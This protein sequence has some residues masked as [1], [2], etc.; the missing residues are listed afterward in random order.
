[1]Q[2]EAEKSPGLPVVIV[3]FPNIVF[4]WYNHREKVYP[5]NLLTSRYYIEFSSN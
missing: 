1:M 4:R 5:F 3:K 2:S